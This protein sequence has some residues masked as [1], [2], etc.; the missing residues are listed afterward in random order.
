M[1]IRARSFSQ[2]ESLISP[3]DVTASELLSTQSLA[4][5]GTTSVLAAPYHLRY[6]S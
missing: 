3:A 1:A 5:L 6:M 2:T 4:T